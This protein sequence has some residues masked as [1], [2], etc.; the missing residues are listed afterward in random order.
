M[1]SARGPGGR[2][3]GL[4]GGRPPPKNRDTGRLAPRNP[5]PWQRRESFW[6]VL[7][8]LDG[9]SVYIAHADGQVW[10]RN[11]RPDGTPP[12]RV[13]EFTPVTTAALAAAALNPDLDAVI[14]SVRGA[15]LSPDGRRLAVGLANGK[16]RVLDTDRW[17]LVGDD[18]PARAGGSVYGVAFTA[19]RRVGDRGAIGRE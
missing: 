14:P 19:D 10:R 6:A 17:A 2:H 12:D 15:D 5:D 18:I 7:D 9:E 1:I 16:V 13:F 8:A 11:T 3:P 4:D